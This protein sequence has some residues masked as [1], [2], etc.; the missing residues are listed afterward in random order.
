[1]KTTEPVDYST[2]PSQKFLHHNRKK[3]LKEVVMVVSKEDFD[4][5][6]HEKKIK[7]EQALNI[8]NM[9]KNSLGNSLDKM[10]KKI[11]EI[12]SKKNNLLKF[13]NNEYNNIVNDG[14]YKEIFKEKNSNPFVPIADYLS[15]LKK[16]T[17][18]NF[19]NP[20]K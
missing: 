17:F 8:I 10:K 13:P 1:M 15:D 4:R 19:S 14:A 11:L 16:D 5:L 2:I 18:G 20:F 12:K 6:K 3:S 7:K 9:K